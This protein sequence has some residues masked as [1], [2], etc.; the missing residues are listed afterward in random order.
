MTI[1]E[2]YSQIY[3]DETTKQLDRFIDI[4]ET[5]RSIVENVE[6]K[7]NKDIH[8]KVM[9]LTADYAHYLTM[10]ERYTKAI[11][12]IQKA[13]KLFESYPDFKDSNLLR[14]E[15]Y[16]TLVFD[17]AVA[18]FYL[19]NLNKAKRDLAK[20]TLEFPGNEKYRTWLTTT[21]AR[22][23]QRLKNVLWYVF[24]GI[25]MI[26]TFFDRQDFGDAYYV[27]LFSAYFI[28]FSTVA[29]DVQNLIRKRK[30]KVE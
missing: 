17:Q 6:I 18:N 15:F 10:Q 13:L 23:D 30:N 28:F 20:L 26:L 3:D 19:Q 14:I 21:K 2:L 22:K 25:M 1:N 4:Y 29:G 7:K 9:R 27:L 5:N 24:A 12:Q 8:N 11:I 16:E